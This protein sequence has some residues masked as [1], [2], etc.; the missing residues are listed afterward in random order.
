MGAS[1][2]T[3]NSQEA[4]STPAVAVSYT[5]L[6]QEFGVEMTYDHLNVHIVEN[7]S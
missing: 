2:S 5:H 4:F 7:R 3:S 1:V 6:F